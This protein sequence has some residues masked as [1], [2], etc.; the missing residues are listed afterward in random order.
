MVENEPVGSTAA[1]VK[2]WLAGRCIARGL[3][4]PINDSGGWRVETGAPDEVR[5][6]VFADTVSGLEN[7]GQS[8]DEPKI[9]LKL[10]G[11][12]R[13]M[14]SVLPPRWQVRSEGH[15]MVLSGDMG[16]VPELP[17][18]Y[19]AN[20]VTKGDV[21][22]ANVRTMDGVI[23]ARGFAAQ[24]GNCFV[25]DR[26]FTD[27]AHRRRGLARVVMTM[28][29]AARETPN[30]RQALVATNQGRD[31]YVTMGWTVLSPWTTAFVTKI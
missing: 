10:L 29:G 17:P 14:R 12:E 1:V 16:P 20:V 21:V 18:E 30:S 3:P 13:A 8:I 11:S 22:E 25:Y 2:D 23:A 28:L 4:K 6:Y 5:R 7:I 31:L 24:A 15:F 9:L 19:E 26:I 27:E